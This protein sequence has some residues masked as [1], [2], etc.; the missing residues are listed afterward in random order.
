M[1]YDCFLIAVKLT[2]K[3]EYEYGQSHILTIKLI[4][5]KARVE[6]TKSTNHVDPQ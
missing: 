3:E 2:F 5:S 6:Q 4:L 1:P